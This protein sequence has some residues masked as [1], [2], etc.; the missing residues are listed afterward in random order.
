M[1]AAVGRVKLEHIRSVRFLS[2]AKIA[3]I[4]SPSSGMHNSK[5]SSQKRAVF[6]AVLESALRRFL[7]LDPDSP[8]L[9]APLT[10][11]VIELRFEP[12]GFSLYFSAADARPLILEN[13]PAEAD[14]RLSGSPLAFLKL[15]RSGD[16]HR[17]LFSGEI[18]VSGDTETARRFQRLF[19]K[20]DIDWE[21]HLSH[22][23]GDWLARRAGNLF[24]ASRQWLLDF[25][26]SNR[27]DLAE[28]FAE[29]SRDV[30]ARNEVAHYCRDVDT[31]RADFDRLAARLA[32]LQAKAEREAARA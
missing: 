21:E 32:R 30:P 31:L 16:P 15:A 2:K 6:A 24:R 29:E 5:G 12:P 18:A 23:S 27:L 17:E 10:G 1:T 28:F 13:Y 20:L 3:M 8:R 25:G 19:D 9:L 11:R 4:P 22:L 7:A 14:V 26:N